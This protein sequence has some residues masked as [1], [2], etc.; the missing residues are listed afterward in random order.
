MDIIIKEC[1]P[2]ITKVTKSIL[3]D[4]MLLDKIHRVDEKYLPLLE[5]MITELLAIKE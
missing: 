3:K 4:E 1:H 2:E 5:S